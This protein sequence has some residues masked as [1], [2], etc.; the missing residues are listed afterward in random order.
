MHIEPITFQGVVKD[1][2]VVPAEGVKLPEGAAVTV[3]LSSPFVMDPELRAETEAWERVS[4][5]AWAMIDTWER[6]G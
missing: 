5:E 2:V 4:D 6:E 3:T 1:G